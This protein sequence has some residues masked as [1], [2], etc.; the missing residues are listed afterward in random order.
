MS[1][2]HFKIGDIDPNAFSIEYYDTLTKKSA[3]Q[4]A[5]KLFNDDILDLFSEV[6]QRTIAFHAGKEQALYGRQR[7]HIKSSALKDKKYIFLIFVSLYTVVF[8][9]SN[10]TGSTL[11]SL[12]SIG[13]VSLAVPAAIFI[14]AF[15][16]LIDSI[17][18]EI[19]GFSIVRRI[20]TIVVFTSLLAIIALVIL[21]LLPT[22]DGHNYIQEL[23]FYGA[24]I[25]RTF[26]VSFI[27]F[28][29]AEY[30]NTNIIA[31]MKY[32][33]RRKHGIQPTKERRRIMVRF[34]SATSIGTLVDSFIFCFG[35]FLFVV[36]VKTILVIVA[37]QYTI[38]LCYDIIACI[39]SSKI[40]LYIKRLEKTDIV[41]LPSNNIA[42]MV[43]F[44]IDTERCSNDYG[45]Y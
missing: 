25:L 24:D 13:G 29:I 26:V 39:F 21:S 32:Y 36:P 4:G 3:T 35:V 6:D 19:Y 28:I 23:V 40:A 2:I 34:I 22:V 9:T 37:T 43:G 45:K 44:K 17:L 15:T 14:Y 12:G 8:F 38:K 30:V 7:K 5:T 41:E 16:F 1:Q 11:V 42:K 10:I 31:R 20:Y 27:S 18:T 33:S